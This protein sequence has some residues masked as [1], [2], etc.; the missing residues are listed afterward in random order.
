MLKWVKIFA[1][2]ILLFVASPVL[3]AQE[4]ALSKSEKAATIE[5][6]SGVLKSNY[7]FPDTAE[8][9]S[10]ELQK[11][12]ESGKYNGAKDRPAFA[13][14]LTDD[15]LEVSNDLHFVI[16]VDP[17]W[18]AEIRA[19]D[20]PK[21]KAQLKEQERLKS[22]EANHGFDDIRRLDG[23]IGYVRF[24]YFANPEFGHD[25]A[26]S[27]MK[28]VENTDAVI[29]DLRYN[30]GGYLEMAQFL[31]SYFFSA[32]KDQLLFD[33]YYYDE[34]KRYERGQWVLP[35]LPGKRMVDKPVYI[36]TASTS[37]SSAEWFPFAM[38]KLG[39]ATLIGERT[40]GGAHPVT[41]LP[42][43]DYFFV[44]TPIGEIRDPVDKT[45]FEGKG[46]TPDIKVRSHRALKVAHLMALEKLAK[47][48]EEKT[49]ELNWL[50]PLL[51][52][53]KIWSAS[54]SENIVGKY[55]G[56]EVQIE[57][58]TLY[59]VWRER[60]RLALYPIA[61]NLYR[62]EGLDDMRFRFLTEN[63]KVTAMERLNRDGSTRIYKRLN[64]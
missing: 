23:N 45:D 60:F 52:E 32:D 18:I 63:G 41:R 50:R 3:P 29:F 57:G 43:N 64:G 21:R 26:A 15:L 44:Q 51:Q 25:T 42:I 54:K 49:N 56:R 35:G 12:L 30:N 22:I 7:I 33:Y 11:N 31:A 5:S 17:K 8:K 16:G 1:S 39:R 6:L 24:T 46:I 34:G 10:Q 14:E 48:D 61:D 36:L 58:E 47:S 37:F 2:I 27:A 59:Y 38:Q 28:F 40:A 9:I 20:D 55:E 53:S 19:Q 4:E 13:S 62:V